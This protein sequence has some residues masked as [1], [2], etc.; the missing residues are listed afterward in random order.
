MK[1]KKNTSGL[2]MHSKRGE[3][4]LANWEKVMYVEREKH[5]TA[6]KVKQPIVTNAVNL[7]KKIEA[8]GILNLEKGY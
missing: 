7:T 8:G 6:R 2:Y 4:H 1:N 3:G 5:W